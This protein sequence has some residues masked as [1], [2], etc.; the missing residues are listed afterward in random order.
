M[1]PSVR[2][3]DVAC[4][5]CDR[6]MSLWVRLPWMPTMSIIVEFTISSPRLVLTRAMTD[7]PEVSIQ[8]ESVDGVPPEDVVTM[9]WVTGENLEDWDDAIRADPTV[10]DVTLVDA[11][12]ERRLYHYRVDESVE[13]Q[14]Y[15]EWIEVGAAQM[16]IEAEDGEW[17]H[18]VRFPDRAAL[19]EFR[20]AADEYGIDFAVHSIYTEP[21][22]SG[23]DELTAAQTEAVEV[24]LEYGY[25]E[26][27]R[28][29]GLEPI[30]AELG[31]SEQSTS[32][33]L[34]RAVR[35]LARK[36]V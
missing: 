31:V 21:Q 4:D 26:I 8:V 29:T 11:F 7:V 2:G 19:R 6:G 36:S 9:L 10:T 12:P 18:R 22:R 15:N 32:E 1:V 25:F 24:A 3:F 28:E 34:R 30:A 33:R 35:K 16:Y 27:P 13:I 20:G 5:D 23:Q 17:F 14:M